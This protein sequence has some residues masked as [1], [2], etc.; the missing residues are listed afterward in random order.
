MS[1]S[2]DVGPNLRATGAGF[3]STLWSTVLA[4]GQQ[5]DSTQARAALE[6]LC[7]TYWRPLYAF[8]RRQGTNPHD[9][10]DL[11]QGFFELLFEKEALAQIRREKGKFRSFLLA[12]L[13]HFVCDQRDNA[14]AQKRGGGKPVFSL[15]V[16]DEEGQYL[17]EPADPLDPEKMFD[18]RWAR[19]LIETVVDRLAA[20]YAA[21]HKQ[22]LYTEIHPFLLEKK[23]GVSQAEVAVR[24]GVKE[25]T[26]GVEV[27]R[28]RQRFRELCR[29]EIAN[30]VATPEQVDEEMRHLFM[31][32]RA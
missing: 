3:Q 5:D 27:H 22:R 14:N 13:R 19:T 20:D 11:T 30:T 21:K 24:L 15:D 26:V 12:S 2:D 4:A 16:R 1:P 8:L 32:L 28:L 18:R 9:A 6:K 25:V 10:E 31:A 17:L 23:T 7:R 29:Q